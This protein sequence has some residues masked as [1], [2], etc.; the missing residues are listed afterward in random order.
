LLREIVND[1]FDPHPTTVTIAKTIYDQCFAWVIF[2][3]FCIIYR[4][5]LSY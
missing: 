1:T 4:T 5:M 3:I 2:R